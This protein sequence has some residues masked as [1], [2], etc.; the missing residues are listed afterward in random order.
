MVIQ[1]FPSVHR[2]DKDNASK[3]SEASG[4]PRTIK[5]NCVAEAFAPLGSC[6]CP[7]SS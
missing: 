4:S 7:T 6:H 5:A 2:N 1:D 3:I